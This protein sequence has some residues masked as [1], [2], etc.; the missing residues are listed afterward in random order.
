MLGRPIEVLSADHQNKTDIGVSIAR[1]WLGPGGVDMILDMGNSS[2]AL[3]VQGLVRDADRVAIPISA[4]T[5]DLTGKACSPNGIQWT[6]NNW[7]NGGGADARAAHAGQDDVLPRHGGLQFRPLAGSGRRDAIT[8]NGGK[9]LGRV[10]HPLN[11]SDFSSLPAAGA[12]SG[13]E[14]VVFA[15]PAPT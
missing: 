13:A 6:Q 5:S 4:V 9:V 12:G 11:T 1:E 14:V 3:A 8:G 10:R 2:I 15:S 7:S